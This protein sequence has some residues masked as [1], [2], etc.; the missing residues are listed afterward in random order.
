MTV[1]NG[2]DPALPGFPPEEAWYDTE[3]A[4]ALNALAT[5]C[6]E[7]GMAFVAVVESRPGIVAAP[8]I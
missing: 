8:T 1:M 3:I 6:H 2:E 4:P 7:R 5:R